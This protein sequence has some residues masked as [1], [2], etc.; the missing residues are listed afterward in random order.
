M[1]GAALLAFAVLVATAKMGTAQQPPASPPE[2]APPTFGREVEVVRVD[3]V[4]TDK[5]GRP[6]RGLTRDDFTVLDEGKPQVLETF[7]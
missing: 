2:A 7:E 1:R 5:S 6:A 4:V 3:V